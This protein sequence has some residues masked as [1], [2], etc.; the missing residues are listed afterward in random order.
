VPSSSRAGCQEDVSTLPHALAWCRLA[1]YR[2]SPS[3]PVGSRDCRRASIRRLMFSNGANSSPRATPKPCMSRIMENDRRVDVV[4]ELSPAGKNLA[5]DG[6]PPRG[7]AAGSPW[8]DGASSGGFPPS[9][10]PRGRGNAGH[11]PREG[12]SGR[13]SLGPRDRGEAWSP[14]FT[15]VLRVL[16][17]CL[18]KTRITR[19]DRSGRT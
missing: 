11:E 6:R 19:K 13:V 12:G 1:P 5:A 4:T 14:A 15:A 9:A 17:G 16:D 8:P 7:F 10:R 18:G 3:V 2:V